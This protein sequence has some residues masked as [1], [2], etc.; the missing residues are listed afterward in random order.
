MS[1]ISTNNNNNKTQNKQTNEVELSMI[2]RSQSHLL[3]YRTLENHGY[4][5]SL[6]SLFF[7]NE[8]INFRMIKKRIMTIA[9]CRIIKLSSSRMIL[10]KMKD[11]TPTPKKKRKA[12]YLQIYYPGTNYSSYPAL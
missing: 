4:R 11:I 5:E 12:Q 9:V 7:N 10:M 2:T 6:K 3:G 1:D 8:E